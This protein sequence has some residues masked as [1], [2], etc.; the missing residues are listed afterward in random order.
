LEI[1]TVDQGHARIGRR[2]ARGDSLEIALEELVAT[3]L[4][5]LFNDLGRILI[6]TVLSGLG[7]DGVD[8][9]HRV[10][11]IAVLTDMLYAPVAKLALGDLINS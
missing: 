3:N 1:L 4:E 9:G 10:V 5:K 2:R 11:R 7:Q 8:G 6:H